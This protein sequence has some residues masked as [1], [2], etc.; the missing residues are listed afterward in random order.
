M[1]I[2][3]S[4]PSRKALLIANCPTGPQPQIGD[5]LAAFE[6]AEIGG[7]EA[8]REDVRQKQDLLVAQAL[9]HLD[10]ADVGVG[11]AQV[12]RLATGI[13]AEHVGIA[14]Q[15][16]R[17]M[18]P[19]LLGHL[20]IRVRALAARK[21]ALLA[22][23]ALAAG[24]RERHHDAVADFELLVFGADLDH[25]AHGLMAEDVALFH[26]GHDAVEQMQVRAADGAGR[27]LDDGIASVLDLGIR[28]GLAA[29]VV[30]AVPGQRLH[31]KSPPLMRSSDKLS[32]GKSVPMLGGT[33]N[34][35][36]R[37]RRS[38]STSAGAEPC[39][40]PDHSQ[41]LPVLRPAS[42]LNWR[43]AARRKAMTF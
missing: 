34:A 19:Q 37:V 27:H 36:R 12:L 23:E 13:A 1:A 30:L 24:D 10:R 35:R 20:V 11:H 32:K 8:G 31:R 6:V 3:R 9:R 22:E 38:N 16:G 43:S 14:E 28:H 15:A 39:P 18:S 29:N 25:L 5:R 2:T 7:H 41:S 26:R 17:R 21:E 4:A 42:D 33:T 40:L